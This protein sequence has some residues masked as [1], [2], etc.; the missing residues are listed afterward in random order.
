MHPCIIP[1]TLQSSNTGDTEIE[2][3]G[4]CGSSDCCDEKEGEE[5][6]PQVELVG[7]TVVETRAR[8]DAALEVLAIGP[9]PIGHHDPMEL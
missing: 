1:R 6:P 8:G 2:Q 3:H 5:V 4:D 9:R 7:G